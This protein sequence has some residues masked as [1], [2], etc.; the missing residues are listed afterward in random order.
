MLLSALTLAPASAAAP[1]SADTLMLSLDRDL[2]D[3][4]IPFERIFDLALHHSPLMKVEDATVESRIL[5]IQ[6]SRVAILNQLSTS[7]GFNSGTATVLSVGNVA[8]ETF[9]LNNGYRYG[10]TFGI[11]VGEL[12]SRRRKIQTA[13]IEHR[14]SVIHRDQAKQSFK[15]ELSQ[16]YQA[17]LLSQKVLRLTIRDAQAAL[18]AFRV[19][20]ISYQKG[21]TA[22][23]EYASASKAYTSTQI[24]VEQKRSEF[25]TKLYDFEILTGVELP[26]LILN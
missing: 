2:G 6:A 5:D 13:K 12:L 15:R 1:A 21:K 8:N 16:A 11:S 25:M 18:I 17:L 23:D 4:L 26:R 22:P 14:L 24:E 3:Q 9:S 10:V 19:A 20:E 7:A